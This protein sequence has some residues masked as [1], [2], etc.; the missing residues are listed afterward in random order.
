M[1]RVLNIRLAR[2]RK[3]KAAIAAQKIRID[4]F[5]KAFHPMFVLKP[6]TCGNEPVL[7]ERMN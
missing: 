1:S 2:R 5:L 4:D 7:P 3:R 6:L